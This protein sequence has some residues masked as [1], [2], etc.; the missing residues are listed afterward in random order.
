MATTRTTRLDL[1]T[2]IITDF[3]AGTGGDALDLSSVTGYLSGWNSTTSPFAAG[4]IRAVASGSDTLIQVDWDASGTGTSWQT[5]VRLQN[6]AP[7]S[8]RA[9]NFT[10]NWSRMASDTRRMA[11]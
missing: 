5:I 2:D 6:V 11:A 10:P 3:A 7:S 9:D 1:K 4:Y 8:L